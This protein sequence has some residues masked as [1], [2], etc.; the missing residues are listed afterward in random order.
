MS[1]GALHI[2]V[3]Y[4][5]ASVGFVALS[6]GA[7]LGPLSLG[8]FALGTLG[9]LAVP[10]GLRAKPG[11]QQLFSA[12]L[13]GYLAFG[14]LRLFFGES[15]LTLGIEL[16]GT[17]QVIKLFQRHRAKD[18]QQIQ[19]L[20]FLHLI[21]ATILSTG[22]EYALVFFAYVFLVPW[23]FALTHLRTE[24]EQHYV[25]ERDEGAPDESAVARVLA[26]R[27]IAGWRFLFATA[28]LAI[29]LFLATA[30]FF[31]LFPRVGMGFLSFGE[32][33]GRQVAGFSGEV[34]LGGFG[35]IRTDPTVVVRVLPDDLPA[36]PPP[37]R[38]FRLR[39]TSF[40]HYE[41][42]RWTRTSDRARRVPSDFGVFSLRGSP[43]G[44]ERRIQI[45]LDPLEPPVLFLPT[46]TVALELSP[47][48]EG[49]TD[50]QRQITLGE[51]LDVRYGDGDGLQQ[52]YVAIVDSAEADDAPARP[53]GPEPER[54]EPLTDDARARYLQLAAEVSPR[55]RELAAQISGEGPDVVRARRVEAWLRS[56]AFT[57]SLALPDTRGRDPL[58][59]FLFE[60]RSGHCEYFST[61]LAIMLRSVDIPA[62]NVTGFVGGAFNPYGRYYAVQQGDA[63]SW[64]E[65]HVGGRWQTFDPTPPA[66]GQMAPPNEGLWAQLN[67]VLDALR[68]R[69]DE[70]VVGYDL[71]R[72]VDALR[73]VFRWFRGFRRDR[74]SPSERPDEQG[75]RAEPSRLPWGWQGALSV[76]LVLVGLWRLRRRPKGPRRAARVP[77]TRLYER[78][79][80]ALGKR[81]LA[82]PRGRT[83]AEHVEALRAMGYA[84]ADAVAEITGAYLRARW[85]E[86]TLEREEAKR[87]GGLIRTLP[88]HEATRDAA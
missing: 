62:R 70:D 60:A 22:L 86:A 12:V 29:P 37:R 48:V 31:L 69:W 43:R 25:A 82:R 13:V 88:T 23:M 57:Y 61:A 16:A 87:L 84:G 33:V 75:A 64:V 20:A 39:G 73:G 45:V 2:L 3:S 17:L 7:E 66:R 71:R 41:G 53:A 5:L 79:E 47:R 14:G 15:L 67:A 8:F 54:E 9:S 59:V 19:V 26:S 63:H 32:G 38:N 51:G 83:P 68:T 44:R 4:L 58:E 56:D 55:L 18:F 30:A 72:Q 52:R 78:L 10:R 81:G 6:L 49:G 46:G 11:Y 36:D 35:V 28:S 76:A 21:A 34:E 42:G 24:I 80:R 74:E 27:R 50:V 1:F 40:D 85:G 77:A 65:A